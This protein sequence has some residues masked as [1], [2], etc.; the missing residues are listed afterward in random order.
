MAFHE[1]VHQLDDGDVAALDLQAA[2]GFK[3]KQT[4]ADH[5]GFDPFAGTLEQRASVI[6]IAKNKNAVLSRA[7]HRRNQWNASRGQEKLVET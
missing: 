4:A 7:L 1:R 2:R 3:A 6:E 5:D